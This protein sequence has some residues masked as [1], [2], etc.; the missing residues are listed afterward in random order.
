MVVPTSFQN[1]TRPVQ[2]FQ[3]HQAAEL[4]RE[5]HLRELQDVRGAVAHGIGHAVGAAQDEDERAAAVLCATEHLREIDRLH[6]LPALVEQPHVTVELVETLQNDL[7]FLRALP[8]LIQLAAGRDLDGVQIDGGTQTL[9]EVPAPVRDPGGFGAAD[10]EEGDLLHDDHSSTEICGRGTVPPPCVPPPRFAGRGQF[11]NGACAYS[12]ALSQAA[13]PAGLRPRG[14]DAGRGHLCAS[15]FPLQQRHRLYMRR[16]RKQIHRLHGPQLV[17]RVQERPQIPREGGRVAGHIHHF[18]RSVGDDGV[19]GLGVESGARRIQNDDV[20]RVL[21]AGLE[22]ILEHLLGTS[23]VEADVADL[24]AAGALERIV[25]G[26]GVALDPHHL[27]AEARQVL[28]DRPHAAVRV[29]HGIPQLQVSGVGDGAVELLRPQR[30]RLEEGERRNFETEIEQSFRDARLA[31][32]HVDFGK[33]GAV[34]ETHV[35][36]DEERCDV[37]AAAEGAQEMLEERLEFFLPRVEQEADHLLARTHAPAQEQH[38]EHPLLGL[39]IEHREPALLHEAA[40][41]AQEHAH[42][43]VV[44]VALVDG[45]HRC[46]LVGLMEPDSR[47]L[48]EVDAPAVA[49]LRAHC[50]EPEAELHLVPVVEHLG[51]GDDVEYAAGERLARRR[52]DRRQVLERL[53]DDLLLVLDLLVVGQVLPHASPAVMEMRAPWHHLILGLAHDLAHFGFREVIPALGDDDLHLLAGNAPLD[54]DRDV[55]DV[56]QSGAAEGQLLHQD[57]VLLARHQYAGG[58]A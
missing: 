34:V 20:E 38:A 52:I 7:R 33:F 9:R 24:V 13:S 22:L 37:R 40:D 27:L 55:V 2:L 12:I 46:P 5:G 6:P 14:R 47:V 50:R 45:K 49:L 28:A 3:E 29:Q 31:G 16:M 23:F 4:M 41:V 43:F 42:R 44:Q 35:L 1:F 54:E 32:E 25:N 19:A 51:A 15:L 8:V 21:A 39:G 10:G 57:C 58:T 48:I 53:A 56:R 36:H 30:V 17:S 26:G 11:Q 18:L